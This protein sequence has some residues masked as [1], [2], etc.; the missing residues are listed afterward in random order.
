MERTLISW[1]LPN[2]FTI[3][4]MGAGTWALIAL[5]VQMFKQAGM[6]PPAG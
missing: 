4:L 6:S 3:A 5:A 1:N 2:V